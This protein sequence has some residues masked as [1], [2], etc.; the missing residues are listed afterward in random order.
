MSNAFLENIFGLKNKVALIVGGGGELGKAMAL[1]LAKAGADVAIA[2]INS[3]AAEA[4]REEILALNRQSLGLEVDVTNSE[5]VNSMTDKVIDKFGHIDI[6]V[7]SAGVSRHIPAHEMTDEDWETVIKINL[8]G[9]FFCCRAVGIH[10]IKQKK[11]SIINIASMSGSITNKDSYNASYCASK[12]GVKMLS[13]QLAEQ[14]AR[15][16]IRINSISPGYMRTQLAI[17]Y[18]DNP[19]NKKWIEMVSPMKRAG[20]PDELIG[21]A[22]Y[23]ASDA[24]SF[25]TGEDVIID[26]GWT[27]V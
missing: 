15:Y 25:V 21:L 11:G 22:I 6:L 24:S 14:W 3:K 18:L 20:M 16:N 26:G 4:V 9:T 13:K 5:M 12:G 23:L 7:N 1:G 17:S 19:K 8:N 10:M 27:I 2:D